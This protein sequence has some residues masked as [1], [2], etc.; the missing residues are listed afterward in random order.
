MLIAQYIYYRSSTQLIPINNRVIDI[1]PGIDTE[2]SKLCLIT[3]VCLMLSMYIY[4]IYQWFR[5]MFGIF[6]Y[7]PK[8]NFMSYQHSKFI[9]ILIFT[10]CW[11]WYCFWIGRRRVSVNKTTVTFIVYRTLNP[12]SFSRRRFVLNRVGSLWKRRIT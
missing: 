6:F 1:Q 12:A 8:K 2:L 9:F 5:F 4:I 3:W 10:M 11:V 7:I